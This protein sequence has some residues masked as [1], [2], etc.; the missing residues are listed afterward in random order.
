M[1]GIR[2]GVGDVGSD[3]IGGGVSGGERKGLIQGFRMIQIELIN[4]DE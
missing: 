2:V 3:S 4:R 1:G